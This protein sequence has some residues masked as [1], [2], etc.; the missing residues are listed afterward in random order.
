MSINLFVM[1]TECGK[2][3]HG[4]YYKVLAIEEDNQEFIIQCPECKEWLKIEILDIATST[5]SQRSL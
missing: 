5:I 2:N 3:G 4:F 1:C